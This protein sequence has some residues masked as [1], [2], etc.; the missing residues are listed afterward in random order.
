M[1]ARLLL[2]IIIFASGYYCQTPPREKSRYDP[3]Y[4]VKWLNRDR[5]NFTRLNQISCNIE[6]KMKELGRKESVSENSF[7]THR[8]IR[9]DTRSRSKFFVVKREGNILYLDV[10]LNNTSYMDDAAPY[11]CG[12]KLYTYYMMFIPKF[13]N[14]ILVRQLSPILPSLSNNTLEFERRLYFIG[15]VENDYGHIFHVEKWNNLI[16]S[17]VYDETGMVKDNDVEFY[18][19]LSMIVVRRIDTKRK[20]YH[21][22]LRYYSH[23]HDKRYFFTQTFNVMI[24]P[25]RMIDMFKKVNVTGPPIPV[26]KR[27]RMHIN[28]HPEIVCPVQR[29]FLWFKSLYHPRI[30]MRWHPIPPYIDSKSRSV[31]KVD[32]ILI[33]KNPSITSISVERHRIQFVDKYPLTT[34]PPVSKGTSPVSKETAP[35]SKKTST[36]RSRPQTYYHTDDNYKTPPKTYNHVNHHVSRMSTRPAAMPPTH[37]PIRY[38]GSDSSVS[39][40]YKTAFVFLLVVVIIAMIIISVLYIYRRRIRGPTIFYTKDEPIMGEVNHE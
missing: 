23:E 13:R 17:L 15:H 5:H 19:S 27:E 18:P 21:I 6:E 24:Y 36:D 10:L 33:F 25:Y 34:L 39:T 32:C 22:V 28:K 1:M 40:K 38:G 3:R 4:E 2:F 31:Y 37:A 11:I 35:V 7:W 30:L 20:N 29:K 26:L 14:T 9:Y 8:G 12:K 16:V